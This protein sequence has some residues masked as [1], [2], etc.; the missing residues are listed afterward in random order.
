MFMKWSSCD[1]LVIRLDQIL[2][3]MSIIILYGYKNLYEPKSV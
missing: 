1:A 2:V 3:D